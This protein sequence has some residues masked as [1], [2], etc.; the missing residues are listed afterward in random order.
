MSF[1]GRIILAAAV[2]FAVAVVTASALAFLGVRAALRNDVDAGLRARVERIPRE[3]REGT[4]PLPLGDDAL[5]QRARLTPPDAY[6][7]LV[8]ADGSVTKPPGEAAGLPVTAR[9]R[10]VAAGTGDTYLSSAV[11]AGVHVRIATAPL[12]AG[13]AIQAARPVDELDRTLHHLGAI[14]ALVA[15][16]GV[17]LAGGLGWVVARAALRPV[18]RLSDTVEHVAATRDLS[19]R[20]DV[21]G[22]DEVARLA[23]R[24][25]EMLAALEASRQAQH[26]LVADAS[27]ELRTP[28]TSLRTN[29]EVLARSDGMPVPE[30]E[31]LLVDLVAQLEDLSVLVADL[32][33]LA[34]E[35]ERA[36]RGPLAGGE[37]ESVRLDAVVERAVERARRRA[38]SLTFRTELEP[39]IVQGVPERLDRAV[40][41]LLDNAVKWSGPG[42]VVEIAVASA[43]VTVRDHGPGIDRADLPFVFDRFYRAPAARAVPGSGLGLAIVRQVAEAHGGTVSADVADGGG[44]VLRVSFAPADSAALS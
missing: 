5:R 29:I 20:I 39:V 40:T 15:A 25:N 9:A 27:H 43:G 44:A 41:N 7:Q 30:R 31:A 14:L 33:D 11:V 19:R 17:A 23:R 22:N 8:N 4:A 28:L 2:A 12:R 42:Q 3:V 36:G 18:S 32:V 13:V 26:Q 6:L 24:F 38:P 34:R 10:A 37:A 21:R 16:A 1:R 35:E